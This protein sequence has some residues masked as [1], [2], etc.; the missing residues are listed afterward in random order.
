MSAVH[1]RLTRKSS[2]RPREDCKITVHELSTTN[3]VAVDTQK[4]VNVGRKELRGHVG[5]ST[6]VVT[7]VMIIAPRATRYTT[8]GVKLWVAMNRRNHAMTR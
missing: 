8:N 1:I 6:P 2:R 3:C 5:A 4:M 7:R